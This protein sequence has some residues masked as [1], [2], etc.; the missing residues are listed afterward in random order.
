MDILKKLSRRTD[1]LTDGQTKSVAM[2]KTMIGT[3]NITWYV[4]STIHSIIND[5]LN[6]EEVPRLYSLY[7]VLLLDFKT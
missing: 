1:Q 4:L 3:K 6:F 7:S 5:L 2:S